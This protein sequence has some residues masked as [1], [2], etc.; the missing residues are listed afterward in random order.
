M[1]LYIL[2]AIAL[3][4][5]FVVA[6][7]ESQAFR[8]VWPSLITVVAGL[9]SLYCLARAADMVPISV[10]YPVWVGGGVFAAACVDVV[11]KGAL[12]SPQQAGC[13]LLLLVAIAGIE[14]GR[15]A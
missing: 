8:N 15:S 11:R 3:E 14:A 10:A 4:A 5:V 12:P 9:G 13:L 1:W 2:P 7:S 6:L